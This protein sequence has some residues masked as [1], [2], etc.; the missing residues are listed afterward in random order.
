M[1]ASELCVH[2]PA[3][4]VAYDGGNYSTISKGVVVRDVDD[5]PPFLPPPL[6]P[7]MSYAPFAP[8]LPAVSEIVAKRSAILKHIPFA[9]RGDFGR[10]LNAVLGDILFFN[11]AYAWTA[12][13][14]FVPCVLLPP[15]RGGVRHRKALERHTK[16]RIV[17]WTGDRDQ[18]LRTRTLARVEMW[19]AAYPSRLSLRA[20]LWLM[21]KP[22]PLS[23]LRRSTSWSPS[24]RVALSFRRCRR[25]RA[26]PLASKTSNLPFPPSLLVPALVHRA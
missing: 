3:K 12:Y 18:D 5:S 23:R 7:Q 6:P 9:C 26:L 2:L 19:R 15:M 21:W 17:K 13:F 24:I 20:V 25:F 16:A 8:D 10:A 4:G 14:L 22:S 1:E 11:D